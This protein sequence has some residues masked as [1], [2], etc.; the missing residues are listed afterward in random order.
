MDSRSVLVGFSLHTSAFTLYTSYRG[1][2]SKVLVQIAETQDCVPVRPGRSRTVLRDGASH[3]PELSRSDRPGRLGLPVVRR[4]DQTA[5]VARGRRIGASPGR[6][7]CRSFDRDLGP[8]RRER[9][10]LFR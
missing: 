2:A 5:A 1:P 9:R 7:D 10:S 6:P 4:A 3:V 8:D